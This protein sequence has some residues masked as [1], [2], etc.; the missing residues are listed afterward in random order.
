MLLIK[1]KIPEMTKCDDDSKRCESNSINWE[2]NSVFKYGI[3]G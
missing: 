3:D 2:N 1:N